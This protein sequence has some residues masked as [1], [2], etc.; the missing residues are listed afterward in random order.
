MQKFEFPEV[1]VEKLRWQC[2]PDELGFKTTDELASCDEIIGQERAIRS[3][4]LGLQMKS[5]GYNIFVAGL[6]GTGKTTTIKHLLE[7][8]DLEKKIP[9]DLCYVYNFM[10]PEMP[11]ALWLSAGHG[12]K[13]AKDI[14]DLIDELQDKLPQIFESE[15]F[16]N[17]SKTELEK[18]KVSSVKLFENLEKQIR[19]EGFAVVKIE[20]GAVSRP[21][22]MP[23]FNGQIVTWE[24][25]QNKVEQKE[26]SEKDFKKLSKKHETLAV[27][28]EN[29]LRES[30]EIEKNIIK[31]LKGLEL[32]FCLP[33]VKALVNDVRE[34]Y[35]SENLDNYFN[36]IYDH[37]LE[38][39]HRFKPG[40][41]KQ[42]DLMIKNVF[43]PASDD[44]LE[45]KVN[46]VV[47]NSKLERVP[48]IT[49][50]EPN[51]R[52][53][54]GTI[55]RVPDRNGAWRTD[56]TK[57]RG[58]SILR[59]NGGY[60]V[61]DLPDVLNEPGVWNAL[62]RTLKNRKL[63]VQAFDPVYMNTVSALKPEAVDID[64]KV[65]LV[66]D[67]YLF[68][69]LYFYDEEFKKIF[70]IKADFDT[71]M[72]RDKTAIQNYAKFIKKI[73]ENEN[74]KAFTSSGVAA[75]IEYGVLLAGRQNKLSTRFSDIADLLREASFWASDSQSE[76]VNHEHVEKA[77]AEKTYRSR[78][79]EDKIQE[80]IDE[81]TLLIE[82]DGA[83]IGEVNGLSVYDLG[84]YSFGR[85]TKITA[86]VSMGRAGIIN[87]EREAELS[88][89]THDKGVLILAGY[90]RGKYAQDKPLTMTASLAF[91]QSYSG[92]D[93][94]SASSTE[95]YALL[96]V[97]SSLPVTQ[98]IA[99]TGSVNQKGD[100]QPIGGVNQKI[101]GFFDVCKSKGLTGRQGAIIPHQNVEDLMLKPGVVEAVKAGKFHIYP[102]KTIDE[103]IEILTG[104]KAGK[105]NKKSSFPG[106]TVNYLVN[107]R[108]STLAK[109]IKDFYDGDG[110]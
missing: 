52:N 1:P 70:K 62:K 65:V 12:K 24:Q 68:Q 72:A 18:L 74:L 15:E 77:I 78:M 102:V 17:R 16:R 47:D 95:I 75:I 90:F 5:P 26:L 31:V 88:G 8:I 25:L 85:P 103:G 76:T 23:V 13:L 48:V 96:S 39:L 110:E 27:E 55:E 21:D 4:K 66:G 84:D 7:Y 83:K 64:L 38:N 100:I 63:T 51:Y 43:T 99:V 53:L 73:I 28:L 20:M 61:L 33:V 42:Q 87:I 71:V 101:E 36:E 22:I 34:K 82:T 14:D 58:G 93:G 10:H 46:V 80:M 98:G 11:K 94:D 56:F 81:G 107:K 109:D 92:V 97:L 37:L 40:D 41:D 44:F 67:N 60:L 106:K 49:E 57:I 108:L 79:V 91:E 59:A 54:F 35:K 86:E 30:R 32:Q 45:F 2:H 69:M 89:S 104:V 105:K 19:K 6:T 9:A 3:I 50:T 29:T